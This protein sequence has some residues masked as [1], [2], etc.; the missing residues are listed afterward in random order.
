MRRL[1]L[2]DDLGRD[3]RYAVHTLGRDPIFTLIVIATLALGIGANTAIFTV[4]N[5][6]LLKHLPYPDPDRVVGL[7]LASSE[8][9]KFGK[10]T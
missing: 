2:M 3:L 1:N 9:R 5:A 6:V 8:A 4:W 10:V 7:N